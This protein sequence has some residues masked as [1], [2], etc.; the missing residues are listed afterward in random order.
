MTAFA[1]LIEAQEAYHMGATAFVPKPF[2]NEDL[3]KA[4]FRCLN[5]EVEFDERDDQFCKLGIN[6]FVSGKTVKYNIF[7]RVGPGKFIKLAHR[8]EDLSLERIDH[9]RR[10]GLHYLYLRHEDF[11][12][13]VGFNLTLAASANKMTS[14]S[15]EK[16]LKL[17]RHTGIIL[18]EQ[19]RHE[20]VDAQVYEAASAFV[21]ASLSI[22]T[23]DVRALDLLATLRSESDEILVHGVGVSL[24]SVMIAEALKWNVAQNR[25]KVAI[26]GL[27]HDIGMKEIDPSLNLKPRY[28]WTRDEVVHYESHTLR[29]VKILEGVDC[30]P[31]DVRDIV[32]QHHENCLGKGFPMSLKKIQIHP[33]AKLVTVADEFCYRVLKGPQSK[34]MSP[35]EAIQ[36]MQWS[37]S[38]QLDKACFEALA[39]IFNVPLQKAASG[40]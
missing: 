39:K 19:I 17:L 34:N 5:P 40:Q 36:D 4:M 32:R 29:G 33:M 11:R 6:D 14:L 23:D 18:K 30:I 31:N 25:F 27:L 16:K 9:Y 7:V 8:G 2:R 37:C 38:Q 10:K 22:L 20:G 15:P 35:E 24:Y 28:S 13:Y 21:H 3:A 12:Q 26:G 1:D